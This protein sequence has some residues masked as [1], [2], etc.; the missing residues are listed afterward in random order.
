MIRCVTNQPFQAAVRKP[1]Q[2]I[3]DILREGW[4][5]GLAILMVA[6]AVYQLS[7]RGF[8]VVGNSIPLASNLGGPV[9]LNGGSPA[10]TNV[11]STESLSAQ[12]KAA[13][14]QAV[15]SNQVV[16]SFADP[17]RQTQKIVFVDARNEEEYKAGHIPGAWLFDPYHPE[18]YFT[19]VQPSCDA[20]DQ[21][22]VYCHSSDCDDSLTAAGLLRDIGIPQAKIA[23]YGGGMEEWLTTGLPVEVGLQNSGKWRKVAKPSELK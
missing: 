17:R 3:R 1:W 16:A 12:I 5:G 22:I 6:V 20:A 15:S 2:V 11:S 14:F 19:A 7:P 13:G 23:V 9:M 18:K 21:V 4:V 10:T 8:S